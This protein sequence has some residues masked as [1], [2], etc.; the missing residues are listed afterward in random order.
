MIV[1]EVFR[2]SSTIWESEG[3]LHI[4]MVPSVHV[5]VIKVIVCLVFLVSDGSECVWKDSRLV[6][7]VAAV[8][9]I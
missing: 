2:A 6:K 8:A 7:L 5:R 9:T 3:R 4:W 1:W